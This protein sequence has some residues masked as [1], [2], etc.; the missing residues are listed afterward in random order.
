MLAR[1]GDKNWALS[2]KT[3]T[4]QVRRITLKEREDGIISNHLLPWKKRDHALFVGF[5]P[6]NNPKYAISVVIE[7]GGG[8]S[9]TAAPL[10][11]DIALILRDRDELYNKENEKLH[12][13]MNNKLNT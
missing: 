5:V 7:H 1:T 10:A 11:R 9:L 3:G 4:S 2:G 8:A 12:A 13:I 6:F